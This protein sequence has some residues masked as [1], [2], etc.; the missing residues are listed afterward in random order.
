METDFR[1]FLHREFLQR[2]Q[3][4]KNYSLRAFARD[5]GIDHSTLSQILRGK[6]VITM[7]A[8]QRLSEKFDLT[9]TQNDAFIETI[10]KN[11]RKD[12]AGFLEIQ[13]TMFQLISEWY[14]FAIFELVTVRSFE[15]NATW[16]SKALSITEAEASAALDRLIKVGLVRMTSTGNLVQEA[17]MITT[18]GNH[19][20][21]DAFQRLQEGVLSLGLQSLKKVPLEKRDQTSVTMAI[22]S[23]RLPEAKRRIK[24]FRRKLCQYLQKDADRDSVFQL[25]VS[26]YPLTQI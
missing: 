22:N 2:C 21:N 24:T 14:H 1:I 16:I 19:F 3:A 15:A 13:S 20:T 25:G 17:S 4:N 6:R 7:K 9:Q 18:I 11:I 12:E 5:I 8:Y 23:K 26:F 10:K